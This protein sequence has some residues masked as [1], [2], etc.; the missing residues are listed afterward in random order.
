MRDI[1]GTRSD[2]IRVKVRPEAR[3]EALHDP[4]VRIHDGTRE[5]AAASVTVVAV[6]AGTIERVA[7][8]ALS[9][10][11]GAFTIILVGSTATALAPFHVAARV[12]LS[13]TA[14]NPLS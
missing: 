8:F 12:D 9:A 5:V 4:E 3:D 7:D 2:T 14:G 10:P 6:D 13:L 1:A 11:V